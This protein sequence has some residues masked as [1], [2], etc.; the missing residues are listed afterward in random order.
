M[1]WFALSTNLV[2]IFFFF[3]CWTFTVSFQAFDFNVRTWHMENIR[4]P[5]KCDEYEASLLLRGNYRSVEKVALTN[6]YMGHFSRI[7]MS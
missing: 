6:T 3:F 5:V 7:L 1:F 4:L 2:K